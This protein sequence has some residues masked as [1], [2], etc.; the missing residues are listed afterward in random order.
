MLNRVKC[1]FMNE[2]DFLLRLRP[3]V[4]TEIVMS[5]LSRGEIQAPGSENE[6]RC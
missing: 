6:P 4:G 5:V 1:V 2:I 3:T